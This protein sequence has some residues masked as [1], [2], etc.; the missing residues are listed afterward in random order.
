MSLVN[1]YLPVQPIFKSALIQLDTLLFVVA[2]AAVGLETKLKAITNTGLK[3][4]Y[5][6]GLSW[7]F[8]ALNS[9]ILIKIFMLDH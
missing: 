9:S 7:I 4:F 8:M 6:A 1:T 3:P 2:M 5:L